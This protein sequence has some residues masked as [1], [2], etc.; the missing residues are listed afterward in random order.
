[1]TEVCEASAVPGEE[2]RRETGS[3]SIR[4]ICEEFLDN[5]LF[6]VVEY[7]TRGRFAD[8]QRGREVG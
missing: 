3:Q 2:I 4:L 5:R 1:M 8:F 7:D 6:S